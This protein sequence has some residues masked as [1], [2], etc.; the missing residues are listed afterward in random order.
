MAI[1][2]TTLA[3]SSEPKVKVLSLEEACE[4]HGFGQFQTDSTKQATD[5][6]ERLLR[7]LS[8]FIARTNFPGI[9]TEHSESNVCG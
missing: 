2:Q 8:A 9:T 6:Q 4:P 7:C 1:S 5:W 3:Q